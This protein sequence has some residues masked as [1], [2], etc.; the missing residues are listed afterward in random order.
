M[1]CKNCTTPDGYNSATAGQII[2]AYSAALAA[3]SARVKLAKARE[4]TCGKCPHNTAIYGVLGVIANAAM[5]A[6][7]LA[8]HQTVGLRMCQL[9]KCPLVGKIY[10]ETGEA[11]QGG[12]P[13]NRWVK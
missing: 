11:N 12:C 8:R 4:R 6:D 13:D 9:C 5:P 10:V 3:D 1:S 7:L 2:E